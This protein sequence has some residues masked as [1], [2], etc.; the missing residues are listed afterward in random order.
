MS[1]GAGGDR[2][3]LSN[4]SFSGAKSKRSLDADE[5]DNDECANQP[6][7]GLGSQPQTNKKA[8][9]DCHAGNLF[10]WLAIRPR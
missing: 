2:N 10:F 3:P 7:L 9:N 6:D 8:T 1:D 4:G 5:T